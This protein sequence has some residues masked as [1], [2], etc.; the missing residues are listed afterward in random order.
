MHTIAAFAD[1]LPGQEI[2]PLQ[3]T[4][5]TA[6]LVR[7]AGASDD[8]APQHWDHKLMTGQ[9]FPGVVVHGWLTFAYMC[10]AVTNW[11]PREIAD[12]T[13]FSVRYHRP[14]FPGLVL[15]GGKVAATRVEDDARLVDLQL[16]AKD[17]G[18]E[19]TTTATMTL[20]VFDAS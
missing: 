11:L 3:M 17:G 20:A 15:C 14:T 6:T 1:L 5:D 8:Y 16:W 19:V 4:V 2:P 12:I 9:G 13:H 7:Y 10:Q 18:G